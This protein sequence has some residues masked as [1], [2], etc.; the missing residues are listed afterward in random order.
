MLGFTIPFKNQFT[1]YFI[2]NP[3]ISEKQE[4]HVPHHLPEQ[5]WTIYQKLTVTLK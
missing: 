2:S 1:S 3:N 4:A 5:Q